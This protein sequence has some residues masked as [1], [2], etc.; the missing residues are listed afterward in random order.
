MWQTLTSI[1]MTVWLLMATGLIAA[2]VLI[3][4]LSV[5]LPRLR[6]GRE[7]ERKV[8]HL[9]E[10]IKNNANIPFHD[11]LLPTA[12][13]HTTQIDHLLISTR[14]I[15]VI[16]T[17]SHYG[18]IKGNAQSKYWK[19][20]AANYTHDF[21]N[22]LMQNASH[23]RHLRN[24]LRQIPAEWFISIIVFTDAESLNISTQCDGKTLLLSDLSTELKRYPRIIERRQ[25]AGIA[26]TIRK[27]DIRN[28][29]A[30]I[31]HVMHARRTARQ[32]KNK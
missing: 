3:Y 20:I 21:Y 26:A 5:L 32:S 4:I 14:G 1:S 11:L 25:L 27:A 6:H 9:L 29:L 17:K 28:P 12:G 30:R 19:Q 2:G 8:Q 15:F 10:S 23:V 18:V 7:G 16:E 22:P 13:G 24:L 31:K